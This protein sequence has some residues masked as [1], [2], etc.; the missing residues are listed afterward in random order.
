MRANQLE[1]LFES[2]P[3]VRSSVPCH[4]PVYAGSRP[5]RYAGKSHRRADEHG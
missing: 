5:R 1:I 3:R 4:H 2:E